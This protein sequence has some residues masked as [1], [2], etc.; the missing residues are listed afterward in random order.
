[1]CTSEIGATSNATNVTASSES[2]SSA[3]WISLFS[4]GRHW[5]SDFLSKEHTRVLSIIAAMVSLGLVSC[6]CILFARKKR[7][8]SKGAYAS[9][10]AVH[11]VVCGTEHELQFIRMSELLLPA[12]YTLYPILLFWPCGVTIRSSSQ[13][14]YWA[15]KQ[16]RR[17][18]RCPGCSGRL[19]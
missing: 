3:D 15:S 19:R 14:F 2:T 12:L 4:D 1:M 9:I 8:Y 17:I 16:E 5:N 7:P 10:Q 18:H 6:C 13:K 11:L